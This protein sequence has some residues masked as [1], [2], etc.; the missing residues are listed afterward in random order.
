[1]YLTTQQ[2]RSAG[3]LGSLCAR[4]IVRNLRKIQPESKKEP[5]TYS[6]QY[7]TRK[8]ERAPY[9]CLYPTRKQ[10]TAQPNQ[11]AR[12]STIFPPMPNQKARISQKHTPAGARAA[13]ELR[14]RLVHRRVAEVALRRGGE[15][16]VI[17]LKRCMPAS[18]SKNLLQ[19][20]LQAHPSH[21]LKP[22]RN[23]PRSS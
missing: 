18:F 21:T 14:T 13:H 23:R 7:P 1:M 15:V 22:W 2:I 5:I 4:R 6:C 12:N 19:P 8:Q 20:R 11:K 10:K 3:R 17:H 9:S 16:S